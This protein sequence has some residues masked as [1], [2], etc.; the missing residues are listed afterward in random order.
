MGY[1]TRQLIRRITEHLSDGPMIEHIKE[2]NHEYKKK[3]IPNLST[4]TNQRNKYRTL[5]KKTRI[6]MDMPTRHLNKL[7]YKGL[8]KLIYDPTFR[9][10]PDL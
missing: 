10:N 3:K 2:A 6:L 1:T 4:G 5:V 9:S 7:S 8:N